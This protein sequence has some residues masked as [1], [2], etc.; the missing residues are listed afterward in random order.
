MSERNNI[1][2][3]FQ[4]KFKD[5]EVT[6]SDKVWENIQSKMNTKEKKTN[7][8]PF[9]LRLCSFAAVFLIGFSVATT[10]IAG[11][12]GLKNPFVN[13]KENASDTEKT[14]ISGNAT[15]QNNIVT[16][17]SFTN[18]NKK[19]NAVVV[20]ESENAISN[21]KDSGSTDKNSFSSSEKHH[22]DVVVSTTGGTMKSVSTKVA[23]R[24]NSLQKTSVINQTEN[25]LTLPT[26]NERNVATLSE[27]ENTALNPNAPKEGNKT[28]SQINNPSKIISDKNAVSVVSKSEEVISGN[29]P[30]ITDD[31]NQIAQDLKENN[32]DA[33]YDSN[34]NKSKVAYESGNKYVPSAG[35][36]E[37]NIVLNSSDTSKVITEKSTSSPVS[38][39]NNASNNATTNT[40]K[41]LS[42]VTD[43]LAEEPKEVAEKAKEEK[44]AE[45][46]DSKEKNEKKSKWIVSSAF[47]PV[48]MN[49]NGTGSTL[50]SKFAEN[51]K[52]YQTSMSY[53]VG[54]QY[55]L[56]NKWT[57]RT[58][59][60]ALNFEY[61]TN[62]IT[63][64]YASN[65]AG[66][67]NVNENGT[68]SGIVVEN[69]NPKGI[70]YG[71]DGM[72]TTRYKGNIN[73][74]IN[75]IEVPVELSYKILNKKFGINVIGGI[76]SI[77][78][79]DN[80]VSLVSSESNLNIGEANNLNKLHFSTN[81]GLGLRYNFMKAFQA[82]LEPMFKYQINTYN[83]DA[84]NFKPYFIGV[85]SGI[86]F[87]F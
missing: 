39:K 70:A 13:T 76:S 23:Q 43:S 57:V 19:N 41:A 15:E 78:L 77:F 30:I 66:L 40:G 14:T 82:N 4:E 69:P 26:S 46:K 64:Y 56:N 37:N 29:H 35:K 85:Y 58:G 68:G 16:T 52:S 80:R 53:G 5:F 48:Y 79:N 84:G 73:H 60:N 7:L 62:N 55:A 54:L 22:N 86:S 83:G 11:P 12:F 21:S 51:S 36:K 47:S 28:I 38:N 18:T 49:L 17:D 67:E 81:V 61:S 34:F 25:T 33:E 71:D 2:R 6:P 74:S 45:E 72:I 42:V 44:T 75:Y 50:D 27:K 31:E 65:G 24:K 9:W 1:D 63:Y 3:L 87:S 10:F 59:I 8:L 20:N 32:S